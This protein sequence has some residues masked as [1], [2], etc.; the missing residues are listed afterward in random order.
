MRLALPPMWQLA[1]LGVVGFEPTVCSMIMSWTH[2]TFG[3]HTIH[4]VLRS[5]SA[6]TCLC[7]AQLY[8]CM[9]RGPYFHRRMSDIGVSFDVSSQINANFVLELVK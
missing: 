7:S 1:E 8:A 3:G 6:L 2:N 5:G 9:A 4:L